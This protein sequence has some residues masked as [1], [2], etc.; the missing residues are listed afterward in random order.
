MTQTQCADTIFEIESGW[1]PHAT[2]ASTGAYGIP[3][4]FPKSKLGDWAISMANKAQAQGHLVDAWIYHQWQD[5]PVVQVEWGVK[6]MI[7][8]YGTPCRAYVF[9]L[10]HHWY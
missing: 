7:G 3:Q 2:N 1:Y 8:R 10:A 6:Y 5:D 4:V 9:H